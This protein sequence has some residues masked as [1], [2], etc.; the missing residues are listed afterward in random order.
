MPATKRDNARRQ[1]G[2]VG[3]AEQ[4]GNEFS[5]GDQAGVNS[6]LRRLGRALWVTRYNLADLRIQLFG[7]GQ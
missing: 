1:P 6:L 7:L 2:E 3:K 4:R 5:G